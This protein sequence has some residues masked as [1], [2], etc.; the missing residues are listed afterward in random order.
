MSF[1]NSYLTKIRTIMNE[2]DSVSCIST[3]YR[4]HIIENSEASPQSQLQQRQS[5]QSPQPQ[6]LQ[7]QQQTQ[8]P[9]QQQTQPLLPTTK[10]SNLHNYTPK[11]ILLY[12]FQ[13]ETAMKYMDDL[14][15]KMNW[16]M[17]PSC[18]RTIDMNSGQKWRPQ[19]F[20]EFIQNEQC[21][22]NY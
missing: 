12:N 4:T 14:Y 20:D 15:K 21:D 19:E 11:N 13:G 8:P 18:F 3:L 9:Q 22:C 2:N 7:Q 10:I 1:N 5:P 17:C 6:P 16:I